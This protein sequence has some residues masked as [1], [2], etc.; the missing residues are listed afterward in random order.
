MI[1]LQTQ[2]QFEKLL[3]PVDEKGKLAPEAVIVYFTAA[4]CG[5]CK[6][7]DFDSLLSSTPKTLVWYKCDVDENKYTL[8]YCGLSKIPS[9]ALIKDGKFF[10]KFSS[11]DTLTIFDNLKMAFFDSAV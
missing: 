5:A 3:K 4:W 7:I 6:R 8:G 2:E 1:P 10:G 9:F 11:S